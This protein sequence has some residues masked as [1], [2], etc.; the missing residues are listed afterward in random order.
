VLL[1]EASG[2]DEGWIDLEDGV[3]VQFPA[4][5]I[6]AQPNEYRN[7]DYW[8]IPART[9]TGDVVWPHQRV[10]DQPEARPPIG[11]QHRYAPLALA[12]MDDNGTLVV[13]AD[14]RSAFDTMQRAAPRQ[15]LTLR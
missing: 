7:G 1:R 10:D 12:T 14:C 3:A 2:I 5:A 9:A 8:L 4:S 15:D 13:D 11:V 6:E